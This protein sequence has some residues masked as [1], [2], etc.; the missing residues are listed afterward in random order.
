VSMI[1]SRRPRKET[2]STQGAPWGRRSLRRRAAAGPAPAFGTPVFPGEGL[3][4]YRYRYNLCRYRLT[5]GQPRED[6]SEQ[7]MGR[8]RIQ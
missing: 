1:F 2:C 6:H 8:Y 7:Q 3:T 5:P 4:L